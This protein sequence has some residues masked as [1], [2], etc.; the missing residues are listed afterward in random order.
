[1]STGPEV[2]TA[3][4]TA[5]HEDGSL[6]PEGSRAIFEFVARSGNEGAFVL[7]TTGE[8]ASLDL[9]ER[10]VLAELAVRT[11]SPHM[12]VIVHIG[13]ASKFEVLRL[14]EQARGAGATEVAVITPHFL[15][16]TDAALWDF[17]G[18]VSAA[19]DGMRVFVYVYRRRAGNFVSTA[20]MAELAALPNIVGAKVSEEPL[21]QLAAYRAVVPD[22]FALY[23]GADSDLLRVGAFGA[24]GVVS[25]VSSV[26]PR[27]F[28]SGVEALGA[29]SQ[30]D[31]TA[32]QAAID[33][34]V[35]VIGGDL[36]RMKT[37]YRV[38]GV[39]GGTN[40]MAVLPPDEGGVR[41]IERVVRRYR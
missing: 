14:L 2:I 20:L 33:D 7:G 30:A 15:P 1:M 9:V 22:D 29:G 12:R 11:L 38:L 24:Q 37:A 5:F 18:A 26:V 13:A 36:G 31:L 21:E 10:G 19:A 40:R 3:V 8:F 32:A 34:V 39:P 35:G 23:T 4:P 28:R 6:D 27:P 25:G 17:F 16:A 41:E